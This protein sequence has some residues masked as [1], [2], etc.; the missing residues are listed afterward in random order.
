VNLFLDTSV[1]ENYGLGIAIAL[2]LFS[3]TLVVAIVAYIFRIEILLAFKDKF[4]IL[5]TEGRKSSQNQ[6]PHV[7]IKII[8]II[9]QAYMISLF[10]TTLRTVKIMWQKLYYLDWRTTWATNVL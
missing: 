8:F 3:L 1:I 6:F 7:L 9:L 10:A 5:E 4:A 2:G